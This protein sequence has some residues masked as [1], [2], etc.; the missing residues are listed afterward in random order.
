VALIQIFR[1]G[2]SRSLSLG[3]VVFLIV[4]LQKA[5]PAL[6]PLFYEVFA[7][8][9]IKQSHSPFGPAEAGAVMSFALFTLPHGILRT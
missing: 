7:F 9:V 4:V 1:L 3:K 8:K 5:T 2:I 6:T